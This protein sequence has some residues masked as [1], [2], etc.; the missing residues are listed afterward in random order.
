MLD[1]E[2]WKNHPDEWDKVRIAV[3]ERLAK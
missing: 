2:I 1:I 3:G